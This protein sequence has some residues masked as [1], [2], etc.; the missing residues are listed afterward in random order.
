MIACISRHEGFPEE[1]QWFIAI[2]T[3]MEPQ[4]PNEGQYKYIGCLKLKKGLIDRIL[5]FGNSTYES[6]RTLGVQYPALEGCSRP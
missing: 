6:T 2:G 4:W 3:A 5:H 1:Y